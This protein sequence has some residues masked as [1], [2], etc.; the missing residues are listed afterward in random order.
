VVEVPSGALAD[1][2]SRRRLLA[3][4][5]VMRAAGFA[6]WLL[7][8][9]FDGF[10]LGFV[11]WGASGAMA[12][13]AWEALLYDQL[14]ALGMPGRYATLAGR[15]DAAG[16]VGVIVATAAAG[17]LVALGG[18]RA[19]GWA[20]VVVSLAGAGLA[21]TLPSLPA[22]SPVGD[23]GR[24]DSGDGHRQSPGYRL[25][26]RAGWREA[27]GNPA[28]RGAVVAAAALGGV[29]AVDEYLALLARQRHVPPAVIPWLLVLPAM[30]AAA[31]SLLSGRA[32]GLPSRALAVLVGAGGLL[33]AAGAL[34]GSQPGGGP[35]PGFAA[36]AAGYG[37]L[38]CAGLVA[39]AR[40]QD[41]ITVSRATVTSVCGLL[42]ELTA[43]ALFATIGVLA[44]LFRIDVALAALALPLL[45]LAAVLDRLIGAGSP[46]DGKA[47][48][49][50][51]RR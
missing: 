24:P 39:A 32:A 45:A 29:S 19:A 42:T 46:D 41:A 44:G 7:W 3:L 18:L 49:K 40:L 20:S 26:L 5:G 36:V 6:V 1:R 35:L 14:T 43:L 25:A 38:W 47:M 16:G 48:Q 28:V 4:S 12:S 31:G 10:A 8:P 37:A 22:A 30:A 23:G 17:P 15:A 51:R 33:V 34:A 21:L 9:T 11:S 13:G 50:N 2:V 27:A